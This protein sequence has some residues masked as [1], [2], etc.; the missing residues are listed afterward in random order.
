MSHGQDKSWQ[1]GKFFSFFIEDDYKVEYIQ[2]HNEFKFISQT[3]ITGKKYKMISDR[4]G[5]YLLVSHLHTV[6][7]W[8]YYLWAWTFLILL[9]LMNLICCCCCFNKMGWCLSFYFCLVLFRI[10]IDFVNLC[11]FLWPLR[12]EKMIHLS[13]GGGGGCENGSVMQS[14]WKCLQITCK[15]RFGK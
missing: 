8:I 1:K 11:F 15:S 14:I 13:W 7:I 3:R 10:I 6:C 4:T 2:R 9:F 12:D 5:H